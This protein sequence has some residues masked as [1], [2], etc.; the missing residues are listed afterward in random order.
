MLLATSCASS[1]VQIPESLEAQIDKTLTFQQ[2]VEAPDSYKGRVVVLG[3][4]VLKA[5]QLKD[6]TQLEILQL[7]LA[8]SERPET[9]R[10][11]SQG[12]FLALH[13]QSPDPATFV[14]GTRVTMVGEVTGSATGPMDEAQYR[15]PTLD[16]KHLHVW[17]ESDDQRRGS[18]SP[19]GIG[20]G[21]GGGGG[22]GGGVSIGTGF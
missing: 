6:G 17:E 18:R 15:Y 4:E 21:I 8:D 7:P 13:R 20:L 16:V 19:F 3:G 10:S 22:V 14:E 11:Q 12:R 1:E 9:H 2:V 5:R